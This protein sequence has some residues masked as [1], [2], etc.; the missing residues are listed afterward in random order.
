ASARC[1]GTYWSRQQDLR[2]HHRHPRPA[3]PG[4]TT[5][6]ETSHPLCSFHRSYPVMPPS[7]GVGQVSVDVTLAGRLTFPTNPLDVIAPSATANSPVSR[8]P[9]PPT[10]PDLTGQTVTDEQ[11]PRALAVAEDAPAEARPAGSGP[12]Q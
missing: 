1:V 11:P 6:V 4:S 2:G 12:V 10:A 8:T 5:E 3:S 9:P 7:D